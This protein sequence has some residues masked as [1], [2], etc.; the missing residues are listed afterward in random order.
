MA[1]AARAER[2]GARA[3]ALMC[4][5][6]V[7]AA[8]SALP[9]WAAKARRRQAK[10][11]G[12]RNGANKHWDFSYWER[13]EAGGVRRQRARLTEA[14]IIR[15]FVEAYRRTASGAPD[16]Q[17]EAHAAKVARAY[18]ELAP[19]YDIPADVAFCHAVLHT[20]WFVRT[21]RDNH[22]YGAADL[23]RE[24]DGPHATIAEG[25][26]AHLAAIRDA[27]NEAAVVRWD[28]LKARTDPSLGRSIA[29]LYRQC[30]Y[31]LD[32]VHA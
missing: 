3:V 31:D 1:A 32:Y 2:L 9:R 30:V 20:G 11:L 13:A 25:V 15:W 18:Y 27:A 19:R 22:A 10:A 5:I 4:T 21:A 7:L 6:P 14:Q 17:L 8:V 29:A 23:G 26:N 24:G 12:E 16:D 28:E